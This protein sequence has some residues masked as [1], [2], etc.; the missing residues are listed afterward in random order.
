MTVTQAPTFEQLRKNFVAFP[1]EGSPK[2]GQK[3]SIAQVDGTEEH[4]QSPIKQ[5]EPPAITKLEDDIDTPVKEEVDSEAE[6]ESVIGRVTKEEDDIDDE[7]KP[8][9]S[10]SNATTS[11]LLSSFHASQE[12]PVPIEEQF[13]IQDETSQKTLENLVSGNV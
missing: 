3:R 7:T 2:I 10:K 1:N 4:T 6:D 11:T 9:A 13:I 8:S 5:S 12:V